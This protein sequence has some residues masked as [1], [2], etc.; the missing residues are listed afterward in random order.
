[1]LDRKSVGADLFQH[2]AASKDT[3]G[4]LCV[5]SRARSVCSSWLDAQRRAAALRSRLHAMN[6]TGSLAAVVAEASI[7][8]KPTTTPESTWVLAFCGPE[9][10]RD[11]H[12]SH[13][14]EL[15]G[16][17]A[18]RARCRPG[19][20]LLVPRARLSCPG[21]G[22]L[23]PGA[24]A[25]CRGTGIPAPGRSIPAPGRPKPVPGR[26]ARRPRAVTGPG[27]QGL[28]RDPAYGL[29]L[30]VLGPHNYVVYAE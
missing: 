17:L 28:R 25:L 5:E 26:R 7:V 21:T 2:R 13:L 4:K 12:C 1:M 18:R 15:L 23:C 8:S 14:N 9:A 20:G 11:H 22:A 16:E 27:A 30:R 19:A 10:S 6:D 3:V 29:R 24:G